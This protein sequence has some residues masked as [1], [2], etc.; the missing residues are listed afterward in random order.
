MYSEKWMD[1]KK[2]FV[3]KIKDL[4]EDDSWVEKW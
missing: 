1:L 4:P 2:E 3:S